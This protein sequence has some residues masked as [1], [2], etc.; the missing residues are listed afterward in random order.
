M[1]KGKAVLGIYGGIGTGKSLTC[2]VVKEC[3]AGV[4]DVDKMAHRAYEPGTECWEDVVAAF[5]EQVVDQ[6]NG[7][8]ID[9]K[10]LGGLVFGDKSGEKLQRLNAIV[11]PRVA[12]M[13]EDE[14]QALQK[15][16]EV[17]AVEAALL[18]EAQWDTKCQYIWYFHAE[19]EVVVQRLMESRG[20]SREE[21][22][23]R[24][25]KQLSN[26]ERRSL[27]HERCPDPEKR[28]ELDR[29][30]LTVAEAE[31]S[32]RTAYYKLLEKVRQA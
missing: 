27:L 32:I 18:L 16:H 3:G 12:D 7:G 28:W 6:A 15:D 26:D 31:E 5:G 29:S 23:A 9:R 8:R 2:R 17:V 25:S 21:A 13:I 14:T 4:I 22:E 10:V 30:N 20:L 11:W 19:K 1:S 24:I